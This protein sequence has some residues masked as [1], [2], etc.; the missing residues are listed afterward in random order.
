MTFVGGSTT[1]VLIF[2]TLARS[3]P[4]QQNPTFTHK[5]LGRDKTA[6]SEYICSWSALSPFPKAGWQT[7]GSLVPPYTML[8]FM[9]V[10]HCRWFNE[11]WSNSEAL[12]AVCTFKNVCRLPLLTPLLKMLVPWLSRLTTELEQAWPKQESEYL[13]CSGLAT[14]KVKASARQLPCFS[15]NKFPW[16]QACVRFTAVK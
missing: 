1:S 4:K 10:L 13:T 15:H 6:S 8:R 7:K 2:E 16:K 5:G 14:K 3:H 11:K 12:A 9:A